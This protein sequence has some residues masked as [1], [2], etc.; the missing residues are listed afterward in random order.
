MRGEKPPA[1]ASSAGMKERS[2]CS[3]RPGSKLR[4]QRQQKR[5]RGD[6]WVGKGLDQQRCWPAQRE[7]E[8]DHGGK[9][10]IPDA[11]DPR[12]R[13][14]RV[15]EVSGQEEPGLVPRRSRRIQGLKRRFWGPGAAHVFSP[16]RRDAQHG[17]QVSDDWPL[18]VMDHAPCGFVV[19][20]HLC[21]SSGGE[22]EKER[23]LTPLACHCAE[24]HTQEEKRA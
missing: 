23:S 3:L 18:L 21:R 24:S 1:A 8:V 12:L 22:R 17:H 4:S 2:R 14:L 16:P 10:S 15:Q 7:C 11:C 6:I 19:V 5:A 13:N 9:V 20:L